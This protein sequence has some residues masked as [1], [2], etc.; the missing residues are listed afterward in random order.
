MTS[1]QTHEKRGAKTSAVEG[2]E[3]LYQRIEN[4]LQLGYGVFHKMMNFVW[5][6]L[7]IHQGTID[8]IG[9]LKFFLCSFLKKNTPGKRRSQTTILLLS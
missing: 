3:F 1:S 6:L 5:A 7:K 2:C 4:P 8:Q 9:S